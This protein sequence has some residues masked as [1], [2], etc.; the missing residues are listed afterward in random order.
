MRGFLPKSLRASL[1]VFL[2]GAAAL[3]GL[4]Q[5][6]EACTT[7]VVQEGD[8]LVSISMAA[9]GKLDYQLLFNANAALLRDG[10]GTFGTGTT[11]KFEF[12]TVGRFGGGNPP[13]PTTNNTTYINGVNTTPYS[14]FFANLAG[15]PPTD[16]RAPG[17]DPAT[18]SALDRV[19]GGLEDLFAVPDEPAPA[20]APSR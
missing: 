3:P 2:L 4:A 5:A 6:Q 12:I 20:A 8:T 9:Y 18:K 16:N 19:F 17:T 10:A 13:P 7:H 1:A 14:V 11:P 15:P